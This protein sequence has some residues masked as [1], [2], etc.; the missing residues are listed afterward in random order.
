MW[1]QWKLVVAIHCARYGNIETITWANTSKMSWRLINCPHSLYERY[2]CTCCLLTSKKKTQSNI[3][4]VAGS[5]TKREQVLIYFPIRH[6]HVF[7]EQ[8]G[9]ATIAYREGSGAYVCPYLYHSSVHNINRAFL[10]H[11]MWSNEAIDTGNWWICFDL[12]PSADTHILYIECSRPFSHYSHYSI[13]LT[14]IVFVYS[15]HIR[16]Y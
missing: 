13:P 14:C 12:P 8:P 2:L 16:P 4:H 15:W 11:S 7:G 5:A 10:L 3:T 1:R 9:F 6:C